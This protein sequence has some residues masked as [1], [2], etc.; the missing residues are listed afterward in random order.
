MIRVVPALLSL[1]IASL[2]TAI[3]LITSKYPQ[4]LSLLKKC[5]YLYIYALIYG[6]ISFGVMLGLDQLLLAKKLQ[7]EG[8]GSNPWLQAV[9]I[10]MSAKALLH[11]RFYSVTAAG[12][13]FPLGTET[14]VQLFEPWLLR[15]IELYEWNAVR[16]LITPRAER[17]ANLDEAKAKIIRN[18]PSTFA[19]QERT[20]FETDV[21]RKTSVDDAMEM[22]LGR[23]GRRSFDRVFPN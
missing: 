4:T 21:N 7:L 15:K 2:V 9:A 23:F 10:G 3:E 22:Y 12:Q 16:D 17:Y 6:L 1:L 19:G 11:I 8:V 14:I 5:S 18:L 13:S 20:A